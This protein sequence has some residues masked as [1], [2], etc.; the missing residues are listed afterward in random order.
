MFQLLFFFKDRI[1][2]RDDLA[3]LYHMARGREEEMK[4]ERGRGRKGEREA[5]GGEGKGGYMGSEN[6]V[7]SQKP[8]S[9]YKASKPPSPSSGM[10]FHLLQASQRKPATSLWH[11]RWTH[12]ANHK[13]MFACS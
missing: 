2:V 4:R 12:K 1:A 5:R 8:F 3:Q 10:L 11:G 9:T 13:H 7:Y 6:L